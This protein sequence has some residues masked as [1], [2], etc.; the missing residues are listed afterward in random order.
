M[1]TGYTADVGDGTVTDF[2]RFALRCSRAFGATIMQ[3]DNPADE[4]PKHRE[5]SSYYASAIAEQEAEIARLTAMSEADAEIAMAAELEASKRRAQTYR[6]DKDKTRARY[7]AMLVEVVHWPAP[8]PDHIEFKAFM[9]KQ[10]EESIKFDCSDFELSVAEYA[11]AASW[12]ADH[13]HKAEETLSRRRKDLADDE[14]R[15]RVANA[16]I[17][18]L[19]ESLGEAVPA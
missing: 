18:A 12:R 13:R 3:R 9:R 1:P 8:T 5:V 10:L 19:Y 16:W 7:E 17:D 2:R 6:E 4:L 11:N 14:E 15:C